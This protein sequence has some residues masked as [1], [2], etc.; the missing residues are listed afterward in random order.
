MTCVKQSI[1]DFKLAF[2]QQ[3]FWLVQEKAQVSLATMPWAEETE[4]PEGNAAILSI[5]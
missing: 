3:T 5:I 1:N 4:A 2:S